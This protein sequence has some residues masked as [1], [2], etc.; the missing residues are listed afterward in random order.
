[1]RGDIFL[2]VTTVIHFLKL[3]NWIPTPFGFPWAGLDK[4]GAKL[5]A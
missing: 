1:M 3:L 2:H 5:P 4:L